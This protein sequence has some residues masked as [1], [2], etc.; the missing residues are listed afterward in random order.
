VKKL[1]R[2]LGFPVHALAVTVPIG[3]LACSA[4]FDVASHRAKEISFARPSFWLLVVGVAGGVLA[5][6]VALAHV[7]RLPRGSAA[8]RTGCWHVALTDASMAAYVVSILL[9]RGS[10]YFAPVQ[11]PP[12]AASAIGAVLLLAGA[13]AGARLTY[14]YGVGVHVEAEPDQNSV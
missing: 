12:M 13:I 6:A 2:A 1:E 4:L 8:F 7:L 3:A 9:R 11:R 5:G 14:R 10:N